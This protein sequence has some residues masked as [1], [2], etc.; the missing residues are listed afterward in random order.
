MTRIQTTADVIP[1][2]QFTEAFTEPKRQKQST[3]SISVYWVYWFWIIYYHIHD[4]RKTKTS[5]EIDT[6]IE[7]LNLKLRFEITSVVYFQSGVSVP[8]LNGDVFLMTYWSLSIIIP[9]SKFSTINALYMEWASIIS[10]PKE[11]SKGLF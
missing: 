1:I 10:I 4:L 11:Y 5:S 3:L 7:R 2:N 8:M 9:I 6:Q